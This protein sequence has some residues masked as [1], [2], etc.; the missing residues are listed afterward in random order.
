MQRQDFSWLQRAL[1]QRGIRLTSNELAYS[2]QSKAVFDLGPLPE[3][4]AEAE[5][6][7]AD[8]ER[9]HSAAGST[10]GVSSDGGPSPR[11]SMRAASAR[12]RQF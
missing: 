11:S 4:E 2:L 1:K 3:A 7:G 5:G 8:V 6:C 9:A 10:G 12:L